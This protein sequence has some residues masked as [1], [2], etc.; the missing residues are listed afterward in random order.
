MLI[1]PSFNVSYHQMSTSGRDLF[2]LHLT[3]IYYLVTIQGVRMKGIQN[4]III[5][6]KVFI[7]H[8]YRLRHYKWKLSNYLLST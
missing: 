6:E 1:Y 4:K 3:E 8:V 5:S 7:R 2:F